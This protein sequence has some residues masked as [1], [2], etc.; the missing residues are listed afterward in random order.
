MEEYQ[1][2]IDTYLQ[3][4][5]EAMVKDHPDFDPYL[6]CALYGVLGMAYNN[7]DMEKIFT[8]LQERAEAQ[9]VIRLN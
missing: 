5:C 9:E 2:F 1:I 3:A 8:F 7:Q 4:S 6:A